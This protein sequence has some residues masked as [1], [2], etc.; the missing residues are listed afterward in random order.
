MA[1]KM[2]PAGNLASMLKSQ[3]SLSA[4]GIGSSCLPNTFYAKPELEAELLQ[5]PQ[6]EPVQ[7][8][9][10]MGRSEAT[11]RWPPLFT[12]LS[13][14]YVWKIYRLAKVMLDDFILNNWKF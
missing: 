10:D 14:C 7:P 2:L 3:I 9:K 12:F 8:N 11:V 6:A 1:H 5:W 13:C 4:T